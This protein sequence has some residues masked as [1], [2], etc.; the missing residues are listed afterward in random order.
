MSVLAF[1]LLSVLV[2]VSV[3]VPAL[4]FVH[5]SVYVCV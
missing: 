1:G 5:L 2:S 3:I 4:A